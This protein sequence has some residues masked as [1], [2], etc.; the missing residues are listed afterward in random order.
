MSADAEQEYFSDGI[1]E[2]LLNLLAKIPELRVAAR[3]SSFQFKGQNLNIKE[4]GEQLDVAHVL[5]GS[6][7]KAGT[8]VRITAQL[9]EADTGYHLW[10]DTYD[11]ELTDIFGIQDEI[12]AAIVMALSE[13]LGLVPEEA[14]HAFAAANAEAYNAYLLGQHLIKKRTKAD[15]EAAV[16]QFEKAIELDANYAPAHAY[17]ALGALLLQRSLQTYGTFTLEESLSV[18]KP[19]IERALA[20]D[21]DFADAH[22]IKGLMLDDQLRYREAIESYEE[23]LRLNPSLTDVRNWYA[24]TL[25]TV[26]RPDKAFEVQEAAYKIDP[27]SV[28]TLHNYVNN[29]MLRRRFADMEPV[30]ERLERLDASRAAL[31]RGLALDMQRQAAEGAIEMLRAADL[32]GAQPTDLE[33]VAFVLNRFNLQDEA[34]RI[35]PFPDAEWAFGDRSDTARRLELA[36][37]RYEQRPE[38]PGSIVGLAWAHL[39]AGNDAE[40]R[41]WA[42][43]IL[44]QLDELRSATHPINYLFA[45]DAWQRGDARLVDKY[46]APLEDASRTAAE[47]GIDM[48]AL[49]YWNAIHL[50]MRGKEAEAAAALEFALS[51][52]TVRKDWL[53]GMFRRLK[54]ND[55]PR[56]VAIKA[57]YE[58]Y[59]DG[60]RQKFLKYA[61]GEVG[62]TSWRPLEGTCKEVEQSSPVPL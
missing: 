34:R 14:P 38:D 18:A 47:A 55:D 62:F 33:Q 15:V 48:V 57:N 36:K 16:E 58:S 60:E 46:L 9:I 24:I 7:R 11:R 27:L 30:L 59:I 4:V 3:T 6:V 21:P 19:A 13:T 35:W 61:C 12:S 28:L 45:I 41:E 22:G 2:E 50:Y 43:Q 49:H 20:L 51:R 1:S 44:D 53:E 54:L 23:A 40:A 17:L 42:T 26:G 37:E 25:G 32:A 39:G 10:S 29:L 52:E 56:F 8:R 5:E 31:F